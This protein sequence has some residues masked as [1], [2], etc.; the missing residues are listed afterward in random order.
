[1]SIISAPDDDGVNGVDCE[2]T[3]AVEDE[4][5]DVQASGQVVGPR[6]HEVGFGGGEG[7]AVMVDVGG[8]RELWRERALRVVVMM[9]TWWPKEA[10][11]IA[12][13]ERGVTWPAARTGMK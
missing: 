10:K 3:K 9:L 4:S 7:D 2:G 12:I 1:M 8:G 6:V 5:G 13:S 11:E